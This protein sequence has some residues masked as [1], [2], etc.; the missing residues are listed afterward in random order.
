[1]KKK[2]R[3]LPDQLI[4]DLETRGLTY[5]DMMNEYGLTR[6]GARKLGDHKNVSED[7]SGNHEKLFYI[8]NDEA[9]DDLL[10]TKLPVQSD[11]PNSEEVTR[12]TSSLKQTITN[13]ANMYLRKLEKEVKSTETPETDYKEPDY[14]EEGVTAIIHE[15]DPHFSAHVKNREGETIYDTETADQAT[16]DAFNWYYEQ[17]LDYSYAIDEIILLLGGDLVEGENIYEG[18]AHKVQDRLDK[19]IE[20]ARKRYFQEI[21]RLRHIWDAP[22]KIVCVSGNHGDLPVASSS[23][24]DDIIYSQL[25]D[26]INISEI[27]DV[28]FVK[29]VRSDGVTFN[30]RGWKGY[31]THGEH[32]STHIGTSS[33]QSD[34]YATKDQLGFDAAWR[35]HYHQQ[36]QEDVGGAPVFMTNSR[37]PGDDYTDKISVYGETGN[38]IYFAT[39]EEP[40]KS[41]RRQSQVLQ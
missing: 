38:A 15:T 35:G 2:V 34:W 39:D 16:Q 22:I 25:E 8:E 19:Q 28:K 12:S 20:K 7:K 18:Q 24:A 11:E 21:K 26:M 10:N 5:K 4:K 31:L 1:M 14:Y 32:Y 29:A 13:N 41:V 27:Q 37:K 36:K 40:V 30:Y 9:S 3:N 23:N 6:W 17:M 33:P